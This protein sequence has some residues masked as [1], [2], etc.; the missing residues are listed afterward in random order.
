MEQRRNVVFEQGN[1]VAQ[2]VPH[3]P[4]IEKE[5]LGQ[6]I[7]DNTIIDKVIHYIPSDTIF[8]NEFCIRTTL[9]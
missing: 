7:I 5:L 2:S 3:A 1:V 4:E 6:M 9:T 8:Y